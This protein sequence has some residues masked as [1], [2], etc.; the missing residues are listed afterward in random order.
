MCEECEVAIQMCKPSTEQY[1]CWSSRRALKF[2]LDRRILFRQSS[3]ERKTL[4][5]IPGDM[6]T[7]ILNGH[8]AGA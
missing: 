5:G 3:Q 7:R 1:R 6:L 8:S 2:L 4:G